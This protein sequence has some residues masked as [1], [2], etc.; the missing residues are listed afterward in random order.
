MFSKNINGTIAN[1]IDLEREGYYE[2]SLFL[3]T[4]LVIKYPDC[5]ACRVHMGRV[6]NEVEKLKEETPDN[7]TSCHN[8]WSSIIF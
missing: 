4:K 8:P 2:A 1:A 5:K 7:P 6:A 3:L